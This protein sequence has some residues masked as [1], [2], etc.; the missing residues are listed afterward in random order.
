MTQ[1]WDGTQQT[2]L[3]S[4]AISDMLQEQ[5]RRFWASQAELLDGMQSFAEGW[6]ERRHAGTR[7]AQQ[8]AERMC[9][10]QTPN[11]AIG[12]FQDWAN[13]AFQRLMA[14]RSAYQEQLT[15]LA[16][17]FSPKRIDAPG[18]EATT[19]HRAKAA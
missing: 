3:P 19:I 2:F 1:H 7:A 18:S 15:T 11:D 17:A 12:A 6:F 4:P 5:A 14:D 9:R 10:A 16:F 8:A 13:G